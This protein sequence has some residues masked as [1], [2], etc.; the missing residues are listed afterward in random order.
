MPE[1]SANEYILIVTD[2]SGSV[3]VPSVPTPR[4]WGISVAIT[5][6]LYGLFA[7]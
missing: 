6:G 7:L 5:K 2:D 3:D 1:E 4:G